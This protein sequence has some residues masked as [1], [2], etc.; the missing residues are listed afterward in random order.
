MAD[1]ARE[2]EERGGGRPEQFKLSSLTYTVY[3]PTILFSIGQGAVIPVIPLFARELGSSLAA[4][5]LVVAMRGLGQ[6]FFDIPSG[7]AVSRWGQGRHGRG[8]AIAVVAVGAAFSPTPLVGALL[9]FVMGGGWAFWQVARLAYVSEQVPLATRPRHFD[10]R[11]HEPR[12]QLIGP[13][14]GGTLA[15]LLAS[16]RHCG[17]RSWIAASVHVHRVAESRA[18][19]TSRCRASR[20]WCDG[21]DHAASSRCGLPG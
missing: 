8:H 21:V 2:I 16:K 18:P 4:A 6:L 1:V 7:I 19:S 5:A 20:R 14:V 10:D 12:W 13:V 11:R 9:V 3:I 15:R 17:R